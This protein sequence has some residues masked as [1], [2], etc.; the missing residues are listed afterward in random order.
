MVRHCLFDGGRHRSPRLAGA[1]DDDVFRLHARLAERNLRIVERRTNQWSGADGVNGGV[2]DGHGVIAKYRLIRHQRVL[3]HRGNP[4]GLVIIMHA[5]MRNLKLTLSYD[6]TDFYGWQTQPGFRTVQETLGKA[7]HKVTGERVR[8]IVSGR[9]DA[10]VHAVAQVVN[11]HTQSQHPAHVLL[12]AVNA[13]LPEDV[14]VHDVADMPQ[15]FDANL[16][17]QKK[18]YRYVIQHGS[19]VNLFMRRYCCYCRTR[20]DSEAMRRAAEPLVGW[21]DFSSFETA[22]APRMSSRR[23]I[24]HLSLSRAADFIWL[25]VEA[26]GFLYNMVRA[27]AGTL[28]NVGRGFWPPDGVVGILEACDRRQAGPTAPPQGL[29]LMRVTY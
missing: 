13:N 9:T 28:I 21:H 3:F 23:T 5:T 11:F 10:G 16:D 25:D 26:D 24:T 20:L 12:R 15:A 19:H 27:I 18:L 2:P 7:Y 29:F 14:H 17:A 1:D 8:I 4:L 22:G 6:G